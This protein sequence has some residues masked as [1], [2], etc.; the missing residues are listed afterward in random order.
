METKD[1]CHDTNS[2]YDMRLFNL[3]YSE[4]ICC[5]RRLTF[6]FYRKCKAQVPLHLQR[7]Q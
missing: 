4:P 2:Y 1:G 7:Y 3:N 5:S 6:Y